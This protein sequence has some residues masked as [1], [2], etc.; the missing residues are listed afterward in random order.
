MHEEAIEPV[1]DAG[2]MAVLLADSRSLSAKTC[3]AESA[4]SDAPQ[5]ISPMLAVPPP[6][7][8]DSVQGDFMFLNKMDHYILL[9]SVFMHDKNIRII[10]QIYYKIKK[11]CTFHLTVNYQSAAV[12]HLIVFQ[13]V[14]IPC[15]FHHQ[16]QFSH[17]RLRL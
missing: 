7:W 17:Q 9:M 16:K 1:K 5:D 3:A 2:A 4:E 13:V 8:L 11:L 10:T 14:Q 15:H 6:T 12:S